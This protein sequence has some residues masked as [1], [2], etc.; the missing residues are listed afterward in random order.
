MKWGSWGA[1]LDTKSM[2]ELI[3]QC[4]DHGIY[5]F[6]HADIYGGH[7]TEAEWGE[8]FSISNIDRNQIQIITKCGIMMPSD[9][10]PDIKEK[11]YNTSEAHI[12]NSVEKSLNNL[13]TDY[14]DLLLIHRPSPLLNPQI[15]G[16]AFDKLKQSGKVKFFGVSNF[17]TSQVN[18]LSSFCETTANQIEISP[19]AVDAMTDPMYRKENNTYGLVSTWRRQV[20]RKP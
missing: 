18:L 17:T 7:T 3:T 16:N 8:A 9:Q 2:S 6:D 1:Q 20:I 13:K 4:F 12:L 15:V 10:R 19:Y 14:I 11:H 5:S